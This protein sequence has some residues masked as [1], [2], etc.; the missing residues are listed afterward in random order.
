MGD[1]MSWKEAFET[2]QEII[3]YRYN[4]SSSR[5]QSAKDK[6]W[7]MA[8]GGE[9]DYKLPLEK[10]QIIC[11]ALFNYSRYCYEMAETPHFANKDG[12]WKS[13]GK[14]SEELLIYLHDIVWTDTERMTSE[15][16]E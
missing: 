4:V 14:E 13:L 1:M 16:T 10:R 11:D 9:L 3:P 7:Q 6:V 8:K 2:A 5:V 12:Y 15:V